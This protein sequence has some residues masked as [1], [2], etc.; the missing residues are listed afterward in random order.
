MVYVPEIKNIVGPTV[1]VSFDEDI[2]T[3]TQSYFAELHIQS[4]VID[5]TNAD[6]PEAVEDYHYLIGTDH[7]DDEDGTEYRVT[8]IVNHNG[9]IVAFRTSLLLNGTPNKWEDDIPIHVKDIVRMSS[10]SNNG[11][12]P[13]TGGGL[14]TTALKSVL[15][16]STNTAPLQSQVL[17]TLTALPSEPYH[18]E[19][20]TLKRKAVTLSPASES[21]G[22]SEHRELKDTSTVSR[23]HLSDP[24]SGNRTCSPSCILQEIDSHEQC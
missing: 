1:Q 3:H 18:T 13:V 24:H 22:M 23:T 20:K 16:I 15:D 7:I 17:G 12:T 6:K 11:T 10:S 4:H 5:V 19:T 14:R 2:P 8:R 21:S 9:Y